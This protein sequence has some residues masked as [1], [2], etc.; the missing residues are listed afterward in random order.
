M[1]RPLALLLLLCLV[2]IAANAPASPWLAG[3][4]VGIAIPG[5][6]LDL[7]SATWN[8]ATRTLWVVRQDRRAWEVGYDTGAG[9]FA[10]LRVLLLPSGIGSDIEA[11]TQVDFAQDELYTLAE[12]QGRIA[13]VVNL[14]GTPSVARVW[15]LETPS[16]GYT[17]PTETAAGAGPEGLVF[18][19]DAG[20]MAAGF[21]YPDGSAFAGSTRGMGGLFFVGHQ[22]Q[23]RLHVF[24]LNPDV[25]DDFVNRGSFQTAATETAGLEFDRGDGRLYLWHNPAAGNSLEISRLTS[26]ATASVLDPFEIHDTGA[27]SGNLEGF[28]LVSQASCRE[29]GSGPSERTLFL[30][31]D[32]GSPNLLAYAA[33]PCGATAVPALTL[34]GLAL[35]VAS[36]ALALR[37]RRRALGRHG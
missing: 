37:S 30:T 21:R 29:F 13:R 15:N 14:S 10:V 2:F 6:E 17:L 9:A 35:L 36:M 20:L 27:P 3:S 7:S 19:P 18:V 23:G 28:A 32:G 33:F 26:N 8:P 31:Q 25:S 22:V 1:P 16:N 12:D 24:D 4:G 5:G 11:C 34:R